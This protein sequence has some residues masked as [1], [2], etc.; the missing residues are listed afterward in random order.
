V[1]EVRIPTLEQINGLEIYS[2]L[3][4]LERKPYFEQYVGD[5]QSLLSKNV[6]AFL[7]T[8]DPST[9]EYV[10]AEQA[11]ERFR[12]A[13]VEFFQRYDAFLCPVTP[14]PAPLHGLS[15]YVINGVTVP[16]WNMVRATVP[17]NLTG[18]PALSIRFGTSDDNMPIGVQ[19][20]SRWHAESTVLHLASLLESISGVRKLH[21][22]I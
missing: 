5:H 10:A 18:L 6:A 9:K 22:E 20:V 21:P 8:P 1:E 16:S 19:L 7:K 13:F 12:D 17:F 11:A 2:K 4:V 15:E 14:I 3:N